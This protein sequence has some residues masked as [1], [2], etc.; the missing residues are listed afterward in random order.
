MSDLNK[1]LSSCCV[2]HPRVELPNQKFC[3][4]PPC[5]GEWGGA[6]L[7]IKG[8]KGTR[9]GQWQFL[10]IKS[11]QGRSQRHYREV[12]QSSFPREHLLAKGWR[13]VCIEGREFPQWLVC[14]NDSPG[15]C[16]E[17]GNRALPSPI[18]GA[19]PSMRWKWFLFLNC[20]TDVEYAERE[21]SLIQPA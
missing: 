10:V 11:E 13:T 20:L 14:S 18:A 12:E 19:G 15:A 5:L 9:P 4:L 8:I 21:Y 1:N 3:R 7:K 6:E 16:Q 2:A 17:M